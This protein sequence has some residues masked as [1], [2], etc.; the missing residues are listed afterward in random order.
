MAFSDLLKK[1]R[2]AILLALLILGV[3]VLAFNGLKY[4][5]DFSGGTQFTIELDKA[6]NDPNTMT[7]VTNTISQRL[8][9]S[10]LKDT[11]VNAWGNKYVVAQVGTTDQKEID[12]IESVL[13]K[14]GRF[15]NI[16]DSQILF[17]GEDILSV[18]KNPSQGYSIAD[19]GQGYY[20]WTMP[21]TLKTKSAKIFAE[22]VFHT[23]VPS[24]TGSGYDCPKTF[25]FIDRPLNAIFIITQELYDEEQIVPV[26]PANTQASMID[27]SEIMENASIEYMLVDDIDAN[28]L[29]TL[30]LDVN[31]GIEKIIVPKSVYD[32]S[33]FTDANLPVVEVAKN[34][35][36]PWIWT[37]TGLKSII[38]VNE[39]I[40]NLSAPNIDSTNF[41]VY[42][43][44]LIRGSAQTKD[45]AIAKS[46][47][48]QILLSSGSLPVGV[49]NISKETISPLLGEGF[50]TTILIIG[51]IAVFIVGLAVYIRYKHPSLIAAIMFS[52]LSEVFLIIV[53]ASLIGWRLDLAALVGLI[54]AIGTGVDDVV[55]ITD[56][57][58]K[59]QEE[60]EE[61]SLLAKIKN[62]FFMIFAAA[63]TTIAAMIPILIFGFGFGK[64]TGFALTIITGVLIGIIVT[65]PAYSEIAKY[66]MA[67]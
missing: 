37:A 66:I 46:D 52:T 38:W 20:S 67:K 31:N 39:D 50:L 16:M 58:S 42:Y 33:K 22:K 62:A 65:R 2:V 21:F 11:T 7:L 63:A 28:L 59:N 15:E 36:E 27:F 48:L 49:A 30:K 26:D 3:I 44:L 14:Q 51:L 40:T 47:N 8:D 35:K 53:C 6:V 29:A 43:Q 4:G 24:G 5:L 32:L 55:I 56:E 64:L 10:G 23:C 57:L 1:P 45:D 25:F 18:D 19:T 34:N 61:H 54:A 13:Y 60:K 12:A 17:T 9:W 41:K